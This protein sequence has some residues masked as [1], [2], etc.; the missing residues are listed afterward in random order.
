MASRM[1]LASM[2]S[3]HYRLLNGS[4]L[5]NQ[6]TR[7]DWM[8]QLHSLYSHS[9][10]Y[11]NVR[12]DMVSGLADSGLLFDSNFEGGNLDIAVKMNHR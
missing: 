6:R 11:N 2:N 10:V 12:R 4:P 3:P 7:L 5:I 1:R 9:I 8:L